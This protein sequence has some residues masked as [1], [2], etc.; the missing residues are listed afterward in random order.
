MSKATASLCVITVTI[1]TVMALFFSPLPT[2]VRLQTAA[3]VPGQLQKTRML[4]GTVTYADSSLLFSP[5]DGRIAA[6]HVQTGDGIQEGQLLFSLDADR[7]IAALATLNN[8]LASLESGAAALPAELRLT[9]AKELFQQ[10]SSRAELEALIAAK[11]IRSGAE[12]RIENLFVKQGAYVA[13]GTPLA[14][15]HGDQLCITAL[16]TGEHSLTPREGMA[17]WWCGKDGRPQG[18]L[19]LT[20][21]LPVEQAS[22]TALRLS[23]SPVDGCCLPLRPGDAVAVTLLLDTLPSG[24]LAPLSALGEGQ[25]LWVVSEGV[26][27]AIPVTTGEGNGQQ[28]QVS[29]AMAGMQVIL[30]PDGLPELFAVRTG[31][32]Q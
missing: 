5:L 4:Q 29:D 7:E 22:G 21:V 19:T 24:A 23:F 14:Q 28:I 6:V 3:I 27:K 30:E 26:V 32:E 8:R 16:W 15:M 17:A 20:S 18:Q 9:D 10:A 12:G 31:A 13:A 1:A 2:A 11:Q 25:R